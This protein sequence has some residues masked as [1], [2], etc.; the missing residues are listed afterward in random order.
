M[1]GY[2]DSVRFSLARGR[3][4]LNSSRA[5]NERGGNIS[6]SVVYSTTAHNVRFGPSSGATKRNDSKRDLFL[7]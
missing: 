1:I 7:N 4:R 6:F 2:F 5:T 3:V